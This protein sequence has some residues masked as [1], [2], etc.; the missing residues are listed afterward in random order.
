MIGR[1]PSAAHYV[2]EFYAADGSALY[3][4]CTKRAGD[5]IADHELKPWWPEVAR[6][7]VNRHP[8]LAAGLAAERV[9]IQT[10]RPVHNINH[11]GR[12]R[13]AN[14]GVLREERHQRGELCG[15]RSKCPEC[16]EA[17]AAA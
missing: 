10:L 17:R 8:D 4:G 16:R 13:W 9:R 7:E 6:M 11:T 1:D 2:Y 14:R 3:V 5:R 15:V 12:G